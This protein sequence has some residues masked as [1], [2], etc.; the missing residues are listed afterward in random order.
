[1]SPAPARGARAA[2]RAP[3]RAR[4]TRI[5]AR[6][7]EVYGVPVAPPHGDGLSELVL[8]VLSQST[9]DRNRDIAF[10][11]LRDRFGAWEA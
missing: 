3:E 2:W 1:M 9:N 11:R 6:L 8:T 7:A 5:R 10:L 4:V